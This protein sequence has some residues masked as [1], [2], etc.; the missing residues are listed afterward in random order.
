LADFQFLIIFLNSI[1][2]NVCV[3]SC[4]HDRWWLNVVVNALVSINK[5]SRRRTRLVLGW[6]TI[7]RQVNHFGK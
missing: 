1:F 4:M 3:S 2:D 5:V 7:G 6:V